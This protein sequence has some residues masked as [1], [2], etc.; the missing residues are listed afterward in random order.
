MEA[1]QV[2]NIREVC[3]R[4]GVHVETVRRMAN[5]GRLKAGRAG[6]D[7]RFAADECDRVFLGIEKNQAV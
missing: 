6:R 4:Y 3:A 2:Y 7:F 1:K 5:D